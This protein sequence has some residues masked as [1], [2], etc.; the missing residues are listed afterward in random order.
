MSEKTILVMAG[1]TGGHVY[2]ALAV[3][4]YL[5]D[6]GVRLFWMG[7]RSGIE[8]RIVPEKG[9]PLLLIHVRGLRGKTLLQR[10]LS[11][12]TLFLALVQSLMI[13]LKYRPDA[14]LGL[15]GFTS[16][17][18]GVAAWLLRIPL[19][20][21]E[22]N[23][24]AGLTNRLLAPFA[25]FIMLGF[26][27]AMRGSRA[28]TTGNPVRRQIESIP[29]P[30][31]R[32]AGRQ[33]QPLRLLVLGGSL[34]A[35]ALN[36]VLPPVL[37]ALPA[38]VRIEVHHQAG[39]SHIEST[40]QLYK[41]HGIDSA[42]VDAYINDMAG[43]YSWADLAFCR[44]GASTIGELCNAGV[45]SILVPYPHAVDDHQTANAKYLSEAGAAVLLPQNEM[46]V[47]GI[48]KLLSGLHDHRERLLEMAVAARS[49]AFHDAT[50]L[51][52]SICMGEAAHV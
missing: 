18:G 35:T 11:P 26:P 21:H 13:M 24:I 25:R 41:Q 10:L 5:R 49:R 45:A 14:V 32:F 52:G 48:V 43:A 23:A 44:S 15:G 7:T 51:I 42:K 50:T 8:A 22:Q 29:L 31:E 27:G 39:T 2:P 9:F 12:F 1:G 47:P 4:E 30:Q 33:N 3:A 40:R 38:H 17:P 16:G 19:Y 46:T 37:A 20:I 34:G 36:E 6:R 28:I